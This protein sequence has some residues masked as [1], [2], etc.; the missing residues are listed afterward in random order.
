MSTPPKSDEELLVP[1]LSRLSE[2]MEELLRDMRLIQKRLAKL[3]RQYGAAGN[4]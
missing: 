4:K 1:I 2:I 3:E